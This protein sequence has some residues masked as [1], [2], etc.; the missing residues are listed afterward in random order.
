MRCGFLVDTYA[1]ERLKTLNVWSMFA[2]GD[3]GVRPH[4]RLGRDR[5]P[6]EHMAHQCSAG[7]SGVG[8]GATS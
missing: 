2:D 1:G 3:L 4:P 6:R 7:K 5:T 8:E